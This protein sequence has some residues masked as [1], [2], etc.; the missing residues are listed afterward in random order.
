MVDLT[1]NQYGVL[2]MS[3]TELFRHVLES[4]ARRKES[5]KLYKDTKSKTNLS[6]LSV[7]SLNKLIAI[8]RERTIT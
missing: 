6:T 2:Q 8:A 4:R 7:D 1:T 3:P 5:Y